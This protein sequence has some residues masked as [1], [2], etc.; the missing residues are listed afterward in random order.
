[1][2][3]KRIGFT[4]IHFLKTLVVMALCAALV[5]T[6]CGSSRPLSD[7]SESASSAQ[8][9]ASLDGASDK[10]RESAA[11]LAQSSSDAGTAESQAAS[12]AGSSIDSSDES[13]IEKS[14][15]DSSTTDISGD[16]SENGIVIDKNVDKTKITYFDEPVTMYSQRALNVRS[17]P[18]TDYDI[19]GYLEYNTEVKVLGQY[20]K[21][22]WYLIEFFD[23]EAFASN[24]F[25][26]ESQVDL[27]ALRAQQEAEALAAVEA[28]KAAQQAA[29]Q[30]ANN[31]QGVNQT[32]VQQTQAVAPASPAPVA[33]PAGV[34]FIGDSRCVQMQAAVDG[35][36]CSWICE[37]AKGYVWLND[38]AIARA[39]AIVGKGTKVVICL[40]VNDTG[41]IDNYANL[42]NAY[43]AVWAQRG[44]KTYFCS[45][46][47]VWENPYRT[48]E[49]VKAFNTAM[50]G[51]LAGITW[52][53]THSWLETNGYRLV[54]GLHYDGNTYINLFNYIISQI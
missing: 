7:S 16:L 47:P 12:S 19:Y 11:A 13:D 18:S 48:E 46:N 40:G 20:E 5:L 39:D 53:D 14:G 9:G 37:N 6:G 2:K 51:K 27:D 54:D 31:Q 17:G 42:V 50:P 32:Q 28:Q 49:Q 41:N 26:A 10:E 24:R 35:G 1:M 4:N 38:T 36:G 33:A 22:G 8:S 21:N 34:L 29:A 23:G 45:V 43:A 44:A 25:I 3:E 15:A 30:Q 52:L